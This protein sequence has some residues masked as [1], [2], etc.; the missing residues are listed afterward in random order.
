MTLPALEIIQFEVIGVGGQQIHV[1]IADI[2]TIAE[3]HTGV[4]LVSPRATYTTRIVQL[5]LMAVTEIIADIGAREELEIR[6][7]FLVLHS[8]V[9]VLD[10]SRAVFIMRLQMTHVVLATQTYLQRQLVPEP[11]SVGHIQRMVLR[12]SVEVR[13][14]LV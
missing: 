13:I 12:Q 2:R 9:R 14:V 7:I 3:V 11:V 6:C 1:T 8:R 10:G 4:D 5:Q